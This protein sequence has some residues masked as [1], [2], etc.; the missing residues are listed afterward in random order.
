MLTA[1][2]REKLLKQREQYEKAAESL[3]E[4]LLKLKVG[5]FLLI[6]C[7]LTFLSNIINLSFVLASFFSQNKGGG[8]G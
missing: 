1:E 5:D 8:E 3:D 4:Q 6:F 2:Q 7:V